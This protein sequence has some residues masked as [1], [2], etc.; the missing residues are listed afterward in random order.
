VFLE[1]NLNK[2][3]WICPVCNRPIG[4]EELIRDGLT[5]KILS[6]LEAKC[7]QVEFFVDSTYKPVEEKPVESTSSSIQRKKPA[8]IVCIDLS[9]EESA[10]AIDSRASSN[11]RRPLIPTSAD[12]RNTNH[13]T[14]VTTPNYDEETEVEG[15]DSD[16][17]RE[18]T[19]ASAR[20]NLD[21]SSWLE[22]IQSSS[23]D[24]FSCDDEIEDAARPGQVNVGET[25]ANLLNEDRSMLHLNADSILRQQYDTLSSMTNT[26]LPSISDLIDTDLHEGARK[27]MRTISSGSKTRD[28][29]YRNTRRK[30]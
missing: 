9:D 24:D 8:D 12:Q 3:E 21:R 4:A 19:S 7:L 15:E 10:D 28:S 27:R 5:T 17:S 22:V 23:E 26:F 14:A 2:D 6:E 25:D 11:G 13:S 29:T 16:C 1:M 30:A 18:Q 20:P